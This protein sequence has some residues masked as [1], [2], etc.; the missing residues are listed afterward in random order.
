MKKEDLLI[1]ENKL[2]RDTYDGT[3]GSGCNS[4][5]HWESN[6]VTPPRV[7]TGTHANCSCAHFIDMQILYHTWMKT[8]PYCLIH[9]RTPLLAGCD[10]ILESGNML[11]LREV[12][13]RDMSAL[14]LNFTWDCFP[15]SP[16]PF[17]TLRGE[18]ADGCWKC[19]AEA[20]RAR[21][22]GPTLFCQ[23]TPLTCPL[24]P[25]KEEMV[26]VPLSSTCPQRAI[27]SSEWRLISQSSADGSNVSTSASRGQHEQ[28]KTIPAWLYLCSLK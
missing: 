21:C 14:A 27:Y 1:K 7:F 5:F 9:K 26:A 2:D 28:H 17:F 3:C 18:S 20:H 4:H 22:L 24:C 12:D 13:G 10:Y 8:H 16:C 15:I 23:N 19:A 6:T 25:Q 11:R